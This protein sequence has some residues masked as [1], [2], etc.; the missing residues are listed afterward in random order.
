MPSY[1][2][3][4]VYVEEVPSGIRPIQSVGTSM[5]GIIGRAAKADAPVNE[6]IRIETWTQFCTEFVGD[7]KE[8][9]TL[10]NA[11][12]G[13]LVNGG[14]TCYVVN[15]GKDGNLAPAL[16]ALEPIDE[17]A[18][19]LAPGFTEPGHYDALLGHC[20][21]LRDRVAVLDG[22]E[23]TPSIESLTQVGLSDAPK[24]K[25]G[26][27]AAP[28][29]TGIKKGVRARVSNGGWGAY[30]Y[31]WLVAKDAIT[32]AEIT[33]P[34]SG[35][36]AGI[37]ARSDALRGVHKAPAN[38]VVKGATG[39]VRMI[40]KEE[41]GTLNPAG[42]N[43]IRYFSDQGL[44]LWGARTVDRADS[45]Y[46]YVPVRRFVC[47][48]SESIEQALGWVV[49]EPNSEHLWKMIRRDV[50]AFLTLLWRQGMLRGDT[51]EQAFF[52][53]CDAETNPPDVIASG[54]VVTV[55]GLSVQKPAEF[56][57]FRMQ[58]NSGLEGTE[59]KQA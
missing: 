52:V 56:V 22:P 32:G 36:V 16:A 51:P 24:K 55:I 45:E 35:H 41:Q 48:V 49:F 26:E 57:I 20:E 7:S 8:S 15:C 25:E 53:K 10:A 2:S 34:P 14:S 1:L 17:V 12:W 23:T 37:Y 13:F 54:Q 5:A 47:M 6:A 40:T 39:I 11:V 18:I 38:E 29:A 21:K 58:Q 46:R 33:V 3:P 4:G 30:Y 59:S 43:C 31:P 27:A 28:A 19:V 42:V 44:L 50:G 9:T